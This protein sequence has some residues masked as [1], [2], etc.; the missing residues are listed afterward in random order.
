VRKRKL[1]YYLG[2]IFSPGL[3]RVTVR[4]WKFFGGQGWF[5]NPIKI[6]QLGFMEEDN[7]TNI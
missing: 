1:S 7:E 3:L 4:V 5:G 2:D 6:Y